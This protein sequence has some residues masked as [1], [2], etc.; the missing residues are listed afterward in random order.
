MRLQDVPTS[1]RRER[2][3]AAARVWRLADP[4]RAWASSA[5]ASLR[6]RARARGLPATITTD[7]L[8]RNLPVV[9]PV[10]GVPLR[11]YLGAGHGPRRDSPTVD[12]IDNRRGYEADNVVVVCGR[13]NAIKHD[14]SPAEIRAMADQAREVVAM[15]CPLTDRDR[16]ALFY[17]HLI[18]GSADARS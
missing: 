3:V 8:R 18:H 2:Q 6:H 7:F 9:C 15:G 10:L 14:R 17:D 11:I 16:V 5:H 4:R 13:A 1:S 12:R